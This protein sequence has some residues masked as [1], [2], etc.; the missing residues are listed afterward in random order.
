MLK[1][2][3]KTKEEQLAI[4]S[5]GSAYFKEL[6]VP[7]ANYLKNDKDQDYTLAMEISDAYDRWVDNVRFKGYN[8]AES[9]APKAE[10]VTSGRANPDHIR[11]LY[12]CKD[13]LTPV[14]EV[15]P[16]IGQTVSVAKFKL[17]RDVKVYDLTKDI[18]EEQNNIQFESLFNSIGRMFSRP[19]TGEASKY[20]PTQYLAEEIKRM[21]FD[22]IRFKSSLNEG[23]VNL[24][25][26]DP[27]VCK[28]VS[29]DLVN[30]KSIKIGTELPWIYQ[31]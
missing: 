13:N 10:L 9:T 1:A 6:L 27:E 5:D 29:S 31:M 12:L 16:Y 3:G 4:L 8:A 24:L 17:T 28:A 2:T 18:K 20:I 7:L 22:G 30:V 15:R 14:Y 26:F 21:G 19:Y 23:G 25:L 11:Y